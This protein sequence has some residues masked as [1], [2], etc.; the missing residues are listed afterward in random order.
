MFC[1]YIVIKPEF[2]YLCANVVSTVLLILHSIQL[3][4][5]LLSGRCVVVSIM[6]LF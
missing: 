3:K 1:I 4:T 2:L 6:H 5:S